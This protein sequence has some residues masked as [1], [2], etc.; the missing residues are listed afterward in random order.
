MKTP[1][2]VRLCLALLVWFAP[3]AL[4]AA[5]VPQARLFDGLGSHTRKIT[6]KSAQAQHYFDQG[7]NFLFGF[8]HGASI[9]SFQE[10]ARLDPECAMAYW[11]VA[12]ASGPHINMPM[13][14]PPMAEQAW[15]ALKL[16]QQHAG[17]TTPMERSLIEA[18]AKRY[19]N[20]QPEDRAPLD[21][22]YA[23]AMREVWKKFPQEAD[24]GVL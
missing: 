17:K 9:R 10:A 14:P 11:G 7:L 18:L 24:V 5:D 22:A 15:A 12:L 20:P 16:A 13:V 2:A 6:T 3:A 19:A 23:N 8:H 21:L 4:R 1:P